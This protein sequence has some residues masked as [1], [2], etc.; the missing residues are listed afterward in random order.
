VSIGCRG[1]SSGVRYSQSGRLQ[2]LEAGF[3]PYEAAHNP[4]HG[5]GTDV[6]DGQEA[7]IDSDPY[8]FVPYRGG[9][10]VADA[11]GNDLL[12]VSPSGKISLL[13]VFEPI[14]ETA[15]A[16][17]YGSS[18]TK[19]IEAKA[20]VVPDWVVV[21]PDGALYVGALGGVPFAARS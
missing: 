4:D 17:T 11:G 15:P 14:E 12:F 6:A 20:Q 1:R 13:A 7:A 3:G 5:Q 18:Q 9:F 8:S 16:K 21:G 19:P 10:A 2:E